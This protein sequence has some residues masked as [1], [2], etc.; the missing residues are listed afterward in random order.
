MDVFTNITKGQGPLSMSTQPHL[1]DIIQVRIFLLIFS[2]FGHLRR[3]LL[4]TLRGNTAQPRLENRISKQ[5]SAC[6]L[7]FVFKA[8]SFNT[9]HV[10][11]YVF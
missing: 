4:E 2:W 11:Q 1:M 7:K 6:S 8:K 10:Q 9:C 5:I 3:K